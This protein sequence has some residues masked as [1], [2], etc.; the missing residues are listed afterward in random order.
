[1]DNKT[2]NLSFRVS[3]NLYQRFTKHIQVNF[4]N[5]SA[6]IRDLLEKYL[7]EIALNSGV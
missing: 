2:H 3:E 4:M 1:M 6:V 7:K 5:G